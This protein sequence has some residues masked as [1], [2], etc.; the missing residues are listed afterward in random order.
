MTEKEAAAD[1][2]CAAAFLNEAADRR[3]SSQNED[4]QDETLQDGILQDA[5]LHSP[6]SKKTKLC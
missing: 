1:V 3:R 6:D 4:L 2:L 5:T